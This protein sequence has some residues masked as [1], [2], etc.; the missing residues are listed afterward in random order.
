MR[1]VQG[2]PARLLGVLV[3]LLIGHAGAP[4]QGLPGGQPAN[5]HGHLFPQPPQ[6]QQQPI[7]KPSILQPQ[8]YNPN[9]QPPTFPTQPTFPQPTFPQPT[10][11]VGVFG[12]FT[13][14]GML[15]NKV[16]AN[17]PA[18]KAGLVP[19]DLILKI[20]G[21]VINS[22]QQFENVLANSG[23]VLQ[24]V[25]QRKPGQV[26]NIV[27]NL[28]QG[29]ARIIAPYTLGV[30]GNY[31]PLGMTILKVYDDSPAEKLGLKVGDQIVRI[32]D[33]AIGNDPQYFQTLDASSGD[34]VIQVRRG[35]KLA[36]TKGRLQLC[37]FG[38]LG[39]YT[40]AGIQLEIVHPGTPAARAGLQRDD[41]VLQID[42]K[43]VGSQAAFEAAL[44]QSGG[45]WNLKAKKTIGGT[46]NLQVELMNNSLACWCEPA[47][48]GMRLLN[49]PAGSLAQSIGLTKGDIIYKVDFR[50]TPSLGA[51]QDAL[52][53]ARGVLTVDFRSAV[54]GQ[55]HRINVNLNN[56]RP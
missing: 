18:E 13:P 22:Q 1:P 39:E 30:K 46:G 12:S 4:A 51:L 43:F 28:G 19:G 24:M 14:Q 15:V 33:I 44:N 55:L 31:G 7:F 26:Q 45:T 42:N 36:Q 53:N 17:S 52:E 5:P 6:Q 11:T 20:D 54:T 49:C 8:I 27:V 2:T 10:F 29:G 25:V 38:T 37:R 47:V 9:F 34:V 21:V 41:W 35:G 40:P 3:L 50:Q 23:G 48:K 16:T 32:N 56:Q